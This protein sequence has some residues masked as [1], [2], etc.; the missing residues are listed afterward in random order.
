MIVF[1]TAYSD[2]AVEGFEL[3]AVD[4]LLKPFTKERFLQALEK[5]GQFQEIK[6]NGIKNYFFI[7]ADYQLNRVDFS[8]ILYIEGLD[9][10]LKIHLNSRKPLVARMTM[11]GIHDQLPA[12]KFIRVHRSFIIPFSRIV[13]VKN[14]TIQLPELEVPIGNSYEDAFFA[15]FNKSV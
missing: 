2:Y 1:T 15:L 8:D 14:K 10:Y 5:A 3:N 9:D 7:K 11:K 13:A 12:G 4:Y 6:S